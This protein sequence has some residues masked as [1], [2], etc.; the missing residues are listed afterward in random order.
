MNLTNIHKSLLLFFALCS[1][2]SFV[3]LVQFNTTNGV[4]AE[5]ERSTDET[6][7]GLHY[8]AGFEGNPLMINSYDMYCAEF[9]LLKK[10][11]SSRETLEDLTT[12]ATYVTLV[13][14]ISLFSVFFFVLEKNELSLTLKIIGIV[15]GFLYVA[16][17][18]LHGVMFS[19]NDSFYSALKEGFADQG[20]I[21]SWNQ[22]QSMVYIGG[23]LICHLAIPGVILIGFFGYLLSLIYS[24][25]KKNNGYT[26]VA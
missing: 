20:N 10:I 16:D 8:V 18:A 25:C 19:E 15:L 7:F 22:G 2:T 21:G 14:C 17:V 5:Y 4:L 3:F 11:C 9:N 6:K 26:G 24:Y 1:F 13:F 23:S 12:A